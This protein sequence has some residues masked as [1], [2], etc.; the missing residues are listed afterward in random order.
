[1]TQIADSAH[2]DSAAEVDDSVLIGPNCFIDAGVRIGA[3]CILDNNVTL[4]GNTRIGSGNRFFPNAVIGTE[5]QDMK[6][7]GDPTQLIIGDRNIFRENCTV[8]TGTEVGGGVTRIGSDNLLMAGVHVAHDCI[9]DD[10]LTIANNVLMAGHVN[11]ESHV[12]V[13][14]GVAMHHFVTVG[15]Y[16]YVAGFSRV[17]RD[18]PPFMKAAGDPASVRGPNVEGLKRASFEESD[19]GRI[20]DGYRFL[21]RS[22]TPL[23]V[24]ITT[25][26]NRDVD[27]HLFELVDFLRRSAS[28]VYGRYRE[29]LRADR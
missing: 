3:D 1:M 17:V 20:R 9:L 23:E 5:P 15:K 26:L 19:I 4:T 21:Y 29:T 13:M 7:R 28:G 22:G 27:G 24:N 2:V 10:H 11:L 18:I 6:Y 8:N 25:M 12:S 16:S 14:G